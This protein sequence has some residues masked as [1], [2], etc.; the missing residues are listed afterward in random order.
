MP[1]ATGLGLA[2]LDLPDR[3]YQKAFEAFNPAANDA[4]FADQS[5]AL[6]Y[7]GVSRRGLGHKEL[8]EGIAKPNELPQRQ[9]AA[10]GHFAEAGSLFIAG[11]RGVREEDSARRRVGRPARCD[12]AEMELRL[13]KTKEA[14][15]TAEPFVKDAEL[16]KSKFRPLGLYYHGFACFLL[17]DIPR[18]AKSLESTC[19]VRPAVRPARPLPDGPG[20]CRTGRESRGRRRVRR[21]PAELRGAEEGGG[22]GAQAARQ[23]QERPVGEGPARGAGEGPA[24]GLRRGRGVLRRVPELRGRQVRRGAAEVPGVRQGVRLLPAEGRRDASGRVLPRA[25]QELRRGREDAPAAGESSAARRPGVVLARQGAARP[26]ARDR[27]R[28]TPNARTQGFTVAINLFKDAADKADQLAAR[29]TPTR[30]PAGPRS[31]SN[32]PT[33]ISPRSKPQHAAQIY[34]QILN[35]KLLPAKAEEYCSAPRPPTTSPAT[36]DLRGAHR[37]ASSSSSRTARSCRWCCSAAR[38]TLRESRAAG[39]AEQAAGGEGGVRTRPRS[40]RRW[41][42]SS[43]SSSACTAPDIGLALLF[44]AAGGLGEGHRGAGGDPGAGTQRRPA[45]VGY[46]LA[47]CLIRTAPAKAED[48]LRTTCSARSWQLPRTCS[49]G[50]SPRTRRPSRRPTRC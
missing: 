41:S 45:P 21:R 36:A 29:A 13:G 15:A 39:E 7:A 10:N 26:G 20:P 11:S 4:K 49:T 30:R 35:E 2:L 22:R 37:R 42:R 34:D 50:S 38:R 6:Y 12:T 18:A 48:A 3:D 14:R 31:S 23:V 24:A 25:V 5:L 1:H 32:S 9:Q 19:A 43:R 8:A 33:P 17:N 44:I 40:T 27:S 16:A 47:D 28:T 46:V